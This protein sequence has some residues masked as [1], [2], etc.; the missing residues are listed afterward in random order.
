MTRASDYTLLT[1]LANTA[2]AG[3]L[4]RERAVLLLWFLRN[5]I[6]IDDLDA[7]EFVTDGPDD[8]GIDGLYLEGS[9]GDDDIETLVLLQSK[10]PQAPNSVGVTDIR[11]FLGAATPFRTTDALEALLNAP[12]TD[13]QLSDLIRRYDLVSKLREDKVRVRLIF[14]TAGVLNGDAKQLVSAANHDHGVGYLS[15]YDLD[16]LGP[17][18]KA[19]NEPGSVQATVTVD[20]PVNE[21]FSI[22]T[23]GN[24]ILIAAVKA[25]DIVNWPGIDDRALFELNVRRELSPNRVRKEL[26]GAINRGQDH[27]N[28]LAFHNGLT[29]VC[30]SFQSDNGQ[31]SITNPSVVNGA[32]SAVALYSSSAALTDQLRVLVKFVACGTQSQL[33]REV[34]R[35]SNMQNPVNAR[36]LRARDGRQLILEQEFRDQYPDITFVTRPDYSNPPTTPQVIQNDAAAQL[37]CAFYNQRPW[38]AVKK[39]SLF[40]SDTYPE[41]F[42][43]SI[44]AEHI[45]FADYV[46]QRVDGSKERFPD[47]YRKSWT[48]VS[49]V[50]VYLV[51]QLLRADDDLRDLIG[52]PA[53]ALHDDEIEGKIDA[54]VRHV[55]GALQVWHNQREQQD[56]FDNF[57]VDFKN[58]ERLRALSASAQEHYLYNKALEA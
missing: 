1:Q 10:Y 33:A 54:V 37:L 56:G 19:L 24:E 23:G 51:G 18:C 14:V 20:V 35:R 48:L 7:Y 15:I 16:R 44:T 36:N 3:G 5:V 53:A 49:L 50:A 31:I 42:P 47:D 30:D 13:P 2:E 41:I 11:N 27:P 8:E 26:D 34:G 6:G 40:E 21:R 32:Q 29:V 17:I 25:E 38:L 28:F 39:L 46:K 57:K 55:A 12:G 22:T 43:P 52:D 4:T 58:E 45:I 9:A